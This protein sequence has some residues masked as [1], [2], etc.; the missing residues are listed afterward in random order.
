MA[1]AEWRAEVEATVAGTEWTVQSAAVTQGYSYAV[2]AVA[3][4]T[5]G[6]TRVMSLPLAN[7]PS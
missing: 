2:V 1:E 6:E 7:S 4:R 3:H 5:T